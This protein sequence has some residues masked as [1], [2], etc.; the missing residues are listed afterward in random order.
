MGSTMRYISSLHST[1]EPHERRNSCPLL[2]SC[3]ISSCH[4]GDFGVSKR[5]SRSISFSLLSLFIF[6]ADQTSCRSY[7]G[8][9]YRMRSLAVSHSLMNFRTVGLFR[10]HT[11][12]FLSMVLVKCS[13][14][15]CPTSPG[16]HDWRNR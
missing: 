13:G 8:S 2:R 9:V 3:F 10:S 12:R 1:D 14:W 5:F 4:F 6:L 15:P 16:G 11:L 7:V